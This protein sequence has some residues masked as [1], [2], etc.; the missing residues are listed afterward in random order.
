MPKY[1]IFTVAPIGGTTSG[2][3][4][5]KQW[6]RPTFSDGRLA[7]ENPITVRIITSSPLSRWYSRLCCRRCAEGMGNIGCGGAGEEVAST[8][9]GN[10]RAERGDVIQLLST[11]IHPLVSLC[12][13]L[14]LPPFLMNIARHF[15]HTLSLSL[16]APRPIL[17]PVHFVACV[18]LFSSV[19]HHG[20]GWKEIYA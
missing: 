18:S 7:K 14:Q 12:G 16:S 20:I 8:K 9:E 3:R 4:G 17:Y 13:E 15:T 1:Y 11:E 19:R 10:R 6:K 2:V 5:S